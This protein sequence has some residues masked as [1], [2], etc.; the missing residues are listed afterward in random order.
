MD[1]MSWPIGLLELPHFPASKSTQLL[2]ITHISHLAVSCH[3]VT[4]YVA[5]CSLLYMTDFI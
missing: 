1:S 2:I 4:D 3:L 5:L